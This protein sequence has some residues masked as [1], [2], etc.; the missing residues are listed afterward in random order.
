MN[1]LKALDRMIL[2]LS[3]FAGLMSFSAIVAFVL[4]NMT[5]IV[6]RTFLN[7]S[8]LITEEFSGWLLVWMAFTGMGWTLSQ[9]GH[10]RLDLL[11]KRLSNEVNIVI[12]LFLSLLG[13]FCLS[14]F[15]VFVIRFTLDTYERQLTGVTT[16]HFPLWWPQAG[17]CFGG[18]VLALQFLGLFF[19]NL[20]AFRECIRI[21]SAQEL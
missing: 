5:E 2:R 17:M 8:L 18:V 14:C 20:V 12:N 13:F 3:V 9:D 7:T 10:I 6:I 19:R 1:M 15:S 21:D 16:F 11:T 4:L